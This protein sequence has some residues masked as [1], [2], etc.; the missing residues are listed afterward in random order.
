M[1]GRMGC[2]EQRSAR[3]NAPASRVPAVKH[4]IIVLEK[5]NLQT[6]TRLVEL[7]EWMGVPAKGIRIDDAGS[8]ITG[9]LEAADGAHCCVAVTT[10]TLAV[11]QRTCALELRTFIDTRCAQLLVLSSRCSPGNSDVLTWLTGGLV[12]GVI[13][14]ENTRAFS[15][16]G[17]ARSISREFA[18]LDFSLNRSAATPAF[19]RAYDNSSCI[20]EILVADEHP[21]FLRTNTGSCEIFLLAASETP[22]IH[23]RLSHDRRLEEY[24]DQVIPFLLFLRHCFGAG[25]W[26]APAATARLIID[27]PLL[28]AQYGFLRYDSLLNSMRTCGYGTTIAFIPWNYWRTSR[29]NAARLFGDRGNL[30]ICVHGCDHTN[31]EFDELDPARLQWRAGTAL[32]R[33]QQHEKRTGLP[34][35]PVM[36][37]PQGRFSTAAISALQANNYLAAVNTTCFPTNEGP[38]ALTVA[39]FLRPAVTRYHGFPIFQRRYPRRLI[40]CAFDL[41]VGRPALLVEHHQYFREGYGQ[42]EEFVRGLQTVQPKLTWS[43]LSSQ[44]MG[45]HIMRRVRDDLTGIQFFTNRFSLRNAGRHRTRFLLEKHAPDPSAIAAVLVDGVRVPFSF[46]KDSLLLELEADANQTM[47]VKVLGPP[48]PAFPD[49]TGLGLRYQA[50]VSVRRALSEVRDNTLARHPQVLRAATGLA[51]GLRVTGEDDRENPQGTSSS[52]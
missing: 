52:E 11:L 19:E 25:C 15:L 6:G 50:S 42:I 10:E 49:P 17:R 45:S 34:F 44:L 12:R 18:G 29:R 37:F 48:N 21:V 4:L 24:Y 47:E 16:P 20:D 2:D 5:E 39:D 13:S 38:E 46:R 35:E 22:D 8:P 32:Q 9:I 1:T 28:T 3:E 31:K 41:F 36:V 14:R 7:A 33:L 26:H 30:S 27:D 40:D 23:K 43:T 51:K